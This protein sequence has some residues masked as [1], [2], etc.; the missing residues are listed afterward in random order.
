MRLVQ[1][2]LELPES[3]QLPRALPYSVY[4]YS[5]GVKHKAVLLGRS[6][7]L[8]TGKINLLEQ[9]FSL[10]WSKHSVCLCTCVLTSYSIQQFIDCWLGT[11]YFQP[12]HLLLHSDPTT[13]SQSVGLYIKQF[14]FKNFPFFIQTLS[15]K[16]N[17]YLQNFFFLFQ[18]TYLPLWNFFC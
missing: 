10:L 12:F 4:S 13:F 2:L 14:Y 16:N 15:Q 8:Y 9:L 11:V 7:V 17:N 5:L 3:H 6:P 18:S 1:S